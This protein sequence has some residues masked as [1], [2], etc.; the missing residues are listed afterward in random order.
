[1]KVSLGYSFNDIRVVRE[2]GKIVA[3]LGLWDEAP[4]RNV[5]VLKNTPVIRVA[6][7]IAKFLRL[8]FK[9]PKPPEEGKP[10]RSLYIKH[11]ACRPGYENILKTMLKAVTNEVRRS[12]QI[13]F[14]WGAFHQ[15]DPLK[16]IFS[17]LTKTETQSDMY[18]GPWNTGW[19]SDPENMTQEPA[20]ADFSLV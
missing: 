18:W 4:V 16:D 10:L 13:H 17:G 3:L 11:I 12:K 5:V 8:F 6:L 1:M 14:I 15:A 2:N 19:D 20:F 9:A 7:V